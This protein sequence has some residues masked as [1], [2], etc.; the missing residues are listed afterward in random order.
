LT[1]KRPRSGPIAR[2]GKSRSYCRA[3]PCDAE[4]NRFVDASDLDL[5]NADLRSLRIGRFFDRHPHYRSDPEQPVVVAR[6]LKV[7]ERAALAQPYARLDL[8][9]SSRRHQVNDRDSILG[10]HMLMA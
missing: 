3:R 9:G 1:P 10:T 8:L 5:G 6:V 7:P 2:C 4:W